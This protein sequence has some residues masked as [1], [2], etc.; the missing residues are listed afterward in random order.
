MVAFYRP[1]RGWMP[2]ETGEPVAYADRLISGSP[3]RGK[4]GD[5]RLRQQLVTLARQ[6]LCFHGVRHP[7]GFSSCNTLLMIEFRWISNRRMI[8]VNATFFG[9]PRSTICR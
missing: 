6:Q 4:G 2:L 9:L 7:G 1:W 3:Y 8:A 5:G